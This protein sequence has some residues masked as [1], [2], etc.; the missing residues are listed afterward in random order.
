MVI[1]TRDKR[2][3][4]IGVFSPVPSVLPNPDGT[5]GNF[6]RFQV[7]YSYRMTVLAP[8]AEQLTAHAR[9]I[10]LT[11]QLRNLGFTAHARDISLTLE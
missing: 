2:A 8:A 10:S 4:A 5:I 11:A 9:D 6:D 1:D 3:A 7:A